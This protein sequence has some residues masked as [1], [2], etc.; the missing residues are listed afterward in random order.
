MS[1]SNTIYDGAKLKFKGVY[2]LPLM[3][4]KIYEW[5]QDEGFNINEKYYIE[6]VKPF[7]KI[8]EFEWECK[9]DEGEYFRYEMS[10][11]CF[12]IGANDVE[13]EKDGEKFKLTKSEIELTFNANL[14]T[15]AHDRFGDDTFVKKMYEKYFIEDE[16]EHQ[17]IELYT[18]VH[19]LMGEVK[20]FIN[21]Y[22][23]E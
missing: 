15:N 11:K 19:D 4:K 17:K 14:I 8:I 5:L 20:N 3:Y 9:Q 10:M 2:D 16:I 21:L 12:I 13:T 7:G 23:F 22:H 18:E 6:H 1:E